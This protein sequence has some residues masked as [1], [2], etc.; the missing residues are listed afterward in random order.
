MTAFL[1]HERIIINQKAKLIE[2]VNEFKIRDEDG[3]DIGVIRQEG[4]STLKKAARFVSK[5]DQFMTH[6]LGVY[7]ESGEK[8]LELVRPRKLM[9]SKLQVTDGTGRLVGN[10][11]QKN[12]FGKIRF[13]LEDASGQQLGEI[14][15]ENWRA[16]NFAIVDAAGTEVG[17]ITKTW[18]GL[19]KTLFTTADDYLLEVSPTVS[20][21]LR[22][23]AFASA[24]GVD[25]ALK[26]DSRG[27]S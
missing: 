4:Q 15:A 26:Q 11:V 27:L 24:A 5:L 13:G 10:I 7:D 14:Q 1:D 18:E 22:L 2:L 25:T 20:G 16:W 8:V 23:L 21:S 3:E 19:A 9:K 6:K 17:R 12:V